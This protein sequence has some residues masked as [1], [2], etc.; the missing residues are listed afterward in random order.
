MYFRN[1]AL[2]QTVVSDTNSKEEIIGVHLAR[3]IEH[4]LPQELALLA[5]NEASI[6]FDMKYVEGRLMCFDMEGF[7]QK[8]LIIEEDILTKVDDKE[9]LGPI[10]ICVD[11]SGSMQG[12]PE[13]IAKAIT[14]FMAT[15]V[16]KQN[17]HCFL[18]NF[19][20]KI[21][22]LD[23]SGHMG[24]SKVIGFLQRSFYGGTDMSPALNYALE[25]M[26]KE[27]YEKADLLMISDFIMGTLSS[28]LKAKIENAKQNENKF[29]SLSI[30]NMF[31]N[32]KAKTIFDNEWVYNPNNHSVSSLEGMISEI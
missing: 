27:E 12:S 7:Q 30:G 23:L 11:T 18:I 31:L 10:I 9:K 21:E 22:T 5:D 29:Y 3:D 1:L 26:E 32:K 17:R 28:S 6:L 24:I 14:L 8:E 13:T 15:R 4:V 19:S 20:T 2:I 16:I 25:L